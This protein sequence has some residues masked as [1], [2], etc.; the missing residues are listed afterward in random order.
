MGTEAHHVLPVAFSHPDAANSGGNISTLKSPPQRTAFH[1]AEAGLLRERTLPQSALRFFIDGDSTKRLDLGLPVFREIDS[2]IDSR[3]E[4]FIIRADER[5]KNLLREKPFLEPFLINRFNIPPEEVSEARVLQALSDH[6]VL[7]RQDYRDK[8]GIYYL[9]YDDIQPNDK[10]FEGKRF[11]W[12]SEMHLAAVLHSNLDNKM[13]LAK[14]IMKNAAWLFDVLGYVPNA[15]ARGL[16]DCTQ[17]S[18]HTA[19]IRM[20]WDAMSP[21]EKQSMENQQFFDQMWDFAEREYWEVFNAKDPQKPPQ[22]SSEDPLHQ[23]I[24]KDGELFTI[25]GSIDEATYHT[26]SARGGG[27][28]HSKRAYRREADHSRIDTEMYLYMYEEDFAWR[29]EQI[30]NRS[31]N[32]FWKARMAKRAARI[33]DPN[34]YYDPETGWLYDYDFK[35][36]RRSEVATVTG[37]F[38]LHLLPEPQQRMDMLTRFD[39]RFLHEY[40]VGLTDPDTLPKL[41]PDKA[42]AIDNME[43]QHGMR[44]TIKEAYNHEQ[45]EGDTQ[46]FNITKQIYD[47]LVKAAKVE[48]DPNVKKKILHVAGNV[49]MHAIIGI[50]H[51]YEKSKEKSRTRPQQGKIPEKLH[52]ITGEM[53]VGAQYGDQDELAMGFG[54][55]E[56]FRDAYR[57]PLPSQPQSYDV[58]TAEESVTV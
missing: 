8:K 4:S 54:A 16:D 1:A 34:Y 30:S 40:G 28:D 21:L 6:M 42:D 31:A 51:Y 18:R 38:A 24:E 2:Y 27:W 39:E 9:P 36:K 26:V 53:A 56:L 48:K 7:D 41:T 29:A 3:L 20:I 23:S 46:F 35:N 45:W 11:N 49:L 14:S 44:T 10:A 55:F 17:P 25:H 47:T 50:L 5:N 52:T 37:L 33:I 58:F 57:E 12:D 15:A 32:Q 43:Q 22:F 13:D 19:M